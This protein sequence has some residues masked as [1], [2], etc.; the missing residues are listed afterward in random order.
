MASLI[1]RKGKLEQTIYMCNYGCS[2]VKLP[3]QKKV[4]LYHN[5]TLTTDVCR[6]KYE[7]TVD[8]SVVITLRRIDRRYFIL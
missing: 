7:I 1:L 6:Y 3:S 4:S 5:P 8:Q 2:S